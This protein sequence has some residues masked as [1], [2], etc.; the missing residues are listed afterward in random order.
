[1]KTA[2]INSKVQLLTMLKERLSTAHLME[3]MTFLSMLKEVILSIT[4]RNCNSKMI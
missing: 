4:Q 3:M 2:L 1:M